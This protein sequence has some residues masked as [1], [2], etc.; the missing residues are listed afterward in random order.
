MDEFSTFSNFDNT[1]LNF[2]KGKSPYLTCKYT[3]SNKSKPKT[4]DEEIKI[5]LNCRIF[6]SRNVFS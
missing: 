1:S 4:T 6:F 3:E 2:F 5:L